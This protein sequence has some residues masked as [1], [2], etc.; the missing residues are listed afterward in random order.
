[1]ASLVA[2]TVKHLPTV[3]ETWV[4][5]L[6][7]EDLLEKEMGTHSS[8]LAWKIPWAEEHSRLQPMG[9]Q[10]VG[11]NWATKHSNSCIKCDNGPKSH[12]KGP[13]N[14]CI[15]TTLCFVTPR[16]FYLPPRLRLWQNLPSHKRARALSGL[17]CWEA[18]IL[19][20]SKPL[21]FT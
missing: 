16:S 6:D 17:T 5:S 9:L 18:S 13:L 20:G 15:W 19:Y 3:W 2:Q 1:M 14:T 7:W 11:Q 10:R 8:I 12:G 4:R 21:F